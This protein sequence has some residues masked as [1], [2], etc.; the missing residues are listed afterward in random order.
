MIDKWGRTD[1]DELSAA[2][3]QDSL[4]SGG[5]AVELGSPP[6]TAHSGIHDHSR[7][8]NVGSNGR[9]PANISLP[10]KKPHPCSQF[11]F[12][13]SGRMTRESCHGLLSDPDILY[14]RRLA[15]AD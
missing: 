6:K 13:C 2:G 15:P 12:G 4:V 1:Y 9:S 8:G 10:A 14:C 3:P 11:G 7:P 5:I